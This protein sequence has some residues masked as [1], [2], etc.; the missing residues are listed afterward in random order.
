MLVKRALLPPNYWQVVCTCVA[1]DYRLGAGLSKPFEKAFGG[2]IFHL[3]LPESNS[4]WVHSGAS[5][6]SV[7]LLSQCKKDNAKHFL[8]SLKCKEKSAA[9]PTQLAP[10]LSPKFA[11]HHMFRRSQLSWS[12]CEDVSNYSTHIHGQL[13]TPCTIPRRRFHTFDVPCKH[14]SRSRGLEWKISTFQASFA[15]LITL[16]SS[17]QID[18]ERKVCLDAKYTLKGLSHMPWSCVHLLPAVKHKH[19]LHQICGAA[20]A[21]E[22][23]ISSCYFTGTVPA[24]G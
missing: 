9:P 15:V 13:C 1:R 16:G 20:L 5:L 2:P 3:L 18:F 8:A 21:K 7:L 4:H 17:H 19:L 14:A 12:G 22:G 11:P 10:F 23:Q 24:G 6:T